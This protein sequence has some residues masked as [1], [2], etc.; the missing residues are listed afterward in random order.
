[1]WRTFRSPK[2]LVPSLPLVGEVYF[3]MCWV[4][5]SRGG[6]PL[7]SKRADIA[8]HGRDP[9]ALFESGAGADR[10]GFLAEAGIQT[11]DDF[12]LAEQADHALF[13]LA[14][15]LHEVIQIEVLFAF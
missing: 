12:I 14:I 8:D 7:T 4:K 3:A 6:T 9:V 11:A 15:E 13:E 2:W 5:M 1:M 10:N